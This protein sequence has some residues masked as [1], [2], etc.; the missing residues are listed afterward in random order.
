[1]AQPL[2][3]TLTLTRTE[4]AAGYFQAVPEN[5]L[6]LDEMLAALQHS[7]MDSFLHKSA[8]DLVA[9]FTQ[10]ELRAHIQQA[11]KQHHFI[12]LSLIC[13]HLLLSQG[14]GK[15]RD[16]FSDQRIKEL[17]AHSPLVHL[18]C[19]LE[20]NR[21]LHSQWV[22]LFRENIIS[23]GELPSLAA[24]G[25]PPIC[26]GECRPIVTGGLDIKDIHKH[27][28]SSQTPPGVFSAEKTTATA[29][30]K[31][32]SAGVSL[33]QEM[34]HQSSLSPIALLRKWRFKTTTENG[35]H[36]FTLSGTQTSYGKGLTLEDARVSLSMEIVERC[37]SFAS[38]SKKEILGTQKEYPLIHG[39]W[40]SLV[41]QGE[42]PI[43]P[44]ELAQ[45]VTYRDEPLYWIEG[46]QPGRHGQEKVWLP[47]Q[48]LFLFLNLDE[49]DLFSGLG[50]TGLASG[51]TLAQAKVSA[52]LEVVERHQEGTVPF[53]PAACFRLVAQEERLATLLESHRSLGIDV[54]FQDIT[55]P[56][57]IPC[58]KCFVK[59]M[60]GIIHKGTA[61]HLNA[62]K[63]IVSALTETTY[64]FPEGP[65]S[66]QFKGDFTLVGYE[67][68]PDFTTGSPE[69]D[70][71][72]LE[73]LLMSQNK[74]PTYVDLTRKDMK[75][76]V[77]RAIVP[78]MEIMGDFDQFSRVHPDLFHNYMTR[79]KQ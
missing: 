24:S 26:S 29:L 72:L 21:R 4:A 45:E 40:S 28:I 13:E 20:P 34:R 57:G 54:L 55:P 60:D 27:H 18:R 61:A 50:S 51:N 10:E 76:P 75:I 59:G 23:H 3:Y 19:A 70:L 53:D 65:P 31:L 38:V 32:A 58:C 47:A 74:T 46:V 37:A 6:H 15:I 69:S 71:T 43:N 63:A 33:E 35:R 67:N 73:A 42:N 78:G 9:N 12:L 52:L 36:Q 66:Q 14:R 56:S 17:G 79:E 64:P 68:L 7:P 11:K 8:L 48:A 5:F 41:K 22:R 39:S 30:E 44:Q 25:L 77:V 2:S 16:Y 62:R 49:I 1:M